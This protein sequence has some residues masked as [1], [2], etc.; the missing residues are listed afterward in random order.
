[1]AFLVSAGI[2]LVGAVLALMFL[3]KTNVSMEPVEAV[4][5][6]EDDVDR[7]R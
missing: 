5:D 3:P 7:V 6:K 2:A 1:M 4:T